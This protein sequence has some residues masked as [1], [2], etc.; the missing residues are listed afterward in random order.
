MGDSLPP[1]A[2]PKSIALFEAATER[3][4]RLWK[5][6]EETKSKWRK[7]ENDCRRVP[8]TEQNS[9]QDNALFQEVAG[10]I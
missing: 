8:A 1:H 4:R 10:I 9:A 2:H 3:D 5:V 7:I 6:L